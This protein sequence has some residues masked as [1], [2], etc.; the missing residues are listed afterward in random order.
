[1][2]AC[3]RFGVVFVGVLPLGC[4]VAALPFGCVVE[5]GVVV[6]LGVVDV[7]DGDVVDGVVLVVP[8]GGVVGV[9]VVAGGVVVGATGSPGFGRGF[10]VMP[11]INSLSPASEPSCRYL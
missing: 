2:L 8:P 4:V 10:V 6:L 5:A 7:L 9:V 1:M 11:A 3:A